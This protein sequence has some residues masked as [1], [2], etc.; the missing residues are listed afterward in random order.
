MSPDP[1]SGH[2][3]GNSFTSQIHH[4]C[5]SSSS[6]AQS[7]HT[8]REMQREALAMFRKGWHPLMVMEKRC[9][10]VSGGWWG[11]VFQ[12]CRRYAPPGTVCY[13]SLGAEHARG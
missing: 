1:L 8:S 12:Q 2:P 3:R 11:V 10:A 4:D 6:L 5:T 7:P 13:F 9:A